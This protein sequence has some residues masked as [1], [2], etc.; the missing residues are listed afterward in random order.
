MPTEIIAQNGMALCQ[1]A[2]IAVTG[3][4]KPE[5]RAQLLAA[6]LKACR[7]KHA[8]KPASRER[9]ARKAFGAKKSNQGRQR[10]SRFDAMGPIRRQPLDLLAQKVHQ[11]TG[12]RVG[13]RTPERPH[14]IGVQTSPGE[15]VRARARAATL[16]V[17]GGR[18]CSH[19][20]SPGVHLGAD[21]SA[22]HARACIRFPPTR[23]AASA[24][25]SHVFACMCWVDGWARRALAPRECPVRSLLA[26]AATT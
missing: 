4:A 12:G 11:V 16:R 2:P 8:A 26:M 10:L 22:R 23:W 17:R 18:V 1:D 14:A 7:R 24:R 19:A 9:A 25:S 20:S 21:G 15:V 6:S 13:P 3:C 5:T